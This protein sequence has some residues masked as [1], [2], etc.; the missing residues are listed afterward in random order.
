[1]E[2]KRVLC[3]HSNDRHQMKPT[4]T[5]VVPCYNEQS[6]WRHD[7]WSQISREAEISL[8]FV[9]DGSFDA[10]RKVITTTCTDLG[11]DSLI[12][13]VNGGK[14]EALRLGMLRA[15]QSAPQLVGFLDADAAFPAEE[16]IRLANLAS[17]MVGADYASHDSLWSSRVLLGGRDIQRQASRHYLGR[18]IATLVAPLHGHKVYDTQSGYKLFRA[19]DEFAGCLTEPFVTRW[20]PDIELL[21]RWTN[22]TGS[23]MRIW[24]EPVS[25]WRDVGGSKMNR[26]QYRQLVQD[27]WHLRQGKPE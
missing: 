15:L 2:S 8:L 26:S 21:Q 19:S 27:I 25:G 4:V 7:Y 23:Q 12:L 17:M 6:R 3:L 13:P 24:E 1:M 5:I 10:T 9:D 20:F 18:A 22:S 16:V 11:S 14:G